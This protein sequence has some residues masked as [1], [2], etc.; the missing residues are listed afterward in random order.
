MTLKCQI[1]AQLNG[2]TKIFKA[3]DTLFCPKA[4]T[5]LFCKETTKNNLDFSLT[6]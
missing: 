6:F 1:P 3:Q 2:E 5:T 4:T